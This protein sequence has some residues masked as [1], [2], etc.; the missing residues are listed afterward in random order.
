MNASFPYWRDSALNVFCHRAPR[1]TCSWIERL[2]IIGVQRQRQARNGAAPSSR[3][4]QTTNG[5]EHDE[6]A[7]ATA[8]AVSAVDDRPL[9]SGTKRRRVVAGDSDDA[10]M[11][12]VDAGNGEVAGEGTEGMSR[13]RKG[14]R[15]REPTATLA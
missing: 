14:P 15:S 3:D 6:R 11:V 10:M 13:R 2:R 12:G 9:T 4:G 7:S 8:V 1:A 5:L